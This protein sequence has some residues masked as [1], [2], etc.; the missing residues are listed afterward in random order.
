MTQDPHNQFVERLLARTGHGIEAT[1]PILQ[2]IQRQYHYLPEPVLQRVSDAT[3]IR[4][5]HLVGVSTFYRQFRHRPMGRHTL[6]V[7]HGTACH[8]KASDHIH[9]AVD[10]A[11]RLADGTDTS[12]DNEFTVERVA[13]LGCCTLAPVIQVDH[14]TYG[15]LTAGSVGE[16]LDDFRATRH[17]E[18]T[19]VDLVRPRG[20]GNGHAPEIRVGLG[21][22]C[23][24][25]GSDELFH[26]LRQT[27]VDFGL[28]LAV[29]RVGCV[30]RCYQTPIV[31][32][33]APG[34]PPSV[35]AR[36]EPADAEA[37]VRRHFRPVGLGR[38]LVRWLDRALESLVTPEGDAE[39][40]GR[41]ALDIR[42]P[43]VAPFADRQVR[44]ATEHFGELDP[45]DLDEYLGRGGFQALATV[46]ARPP[47]HTI[48]DISASGLR[49]RG[50][51][52]YPTGTK[53]QQ[54]RA[55][56]AIDG[57]KYVI[58]NG[59]EG[60]PGAFMDRMLME[61]FPFR[62]IEG[63]MIA[64][65]CI[66]AGE[67]YVYV[68]AEYP[69]AV[70]RLRAAM[71]AL[72]QRGTLGDN[73]LGTGF[74]F[75]L[76][77]FEGAGAFVCGE[78]TA[79]LESIEGRRGIPRL[80]PPYPAERGLGGRP[81]LVNNIETFVTVPWIVRHGPA[82][83]AAVGTETSKGTKVFALAGEVNR[84]GLIEV[85]MGITI[86]E[87][88]EEI[89]GGVPDGRRFKAVQI[90]GPSG[91]CLPSSMAH[92]PVDFEALKAA[93]AIMGSGGLI[94]LD[95]DDCLVDM[96]RYFLSFL[97]DESCGECTFCRIGTTR[98]FEILDRICAGQGRAGDL[99]ELEELAG[100]TTQGSIC[101]LGR[102]APN[103]V[104]T[105]LRYFRDEY[106]AHL[107]GRCPAGRCSALIRYTVDDDCT[108]CT[109][110]AQHCPTQ[111][112]AATPYQKHFID[113]DKCT[114]CDVCRLLCPEEAIAV[115]SGGRRC[116]GHL[117]RQPEL[118][119]L[120]R[121]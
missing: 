35:Y 61:S 9:E 109:I 33:N 17:A 85:P 103:P 60:D 23:M 37:I 45:L 76:R 10:R 66:G 90:G 62:L 38:R 97:R 34:Q 67:G 106:E 99:A 19:D 29:K 18:V 73:V 86:R 75:R 3:G 6:R 91:G 36:V 105:T 77:L 48:A 50:G 8:V 13:C 120:T 30:G 46:L 4:L 42:D 12:A 40:E 31:E 80:R 71:E 26:R 57:V 110:C 83:Y 79:L 41:H 114:R 1:I 111:A 54:V 108:G 58:A 70:S 7:C 25:K 39:R 53:W 52:G 14:T 93:G 113:T 104:L 68:R 100:Y 72:E 98:M 118:A 56:P 95:E 102:T 115:E 16:M 28:D 89:G 24:A 88:V 51:A 92:V 96:A 43:S 81:T 119:P 69:R 74:G 64:A 47:D 117:H 2:A 15:H 55:A 32:V 78:E 121:I 107:Q 44:I 116:D 20:N 11:L 63:M 49:G 65:Y 112:I 101:G 87:I 21:S 82:A 22:C 94:V 84:A 59:D 5:A 27:A